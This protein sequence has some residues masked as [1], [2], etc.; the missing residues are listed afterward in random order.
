M[1]DDFN[2][3]IG[4]FVDQKLSDPSGYENLVKDAKV[5]ISGSSKTQDPSSPF[6][7]K[8]L[9]KAVRNMI[10]HCVIND[11]KIL[12]GD[13]PGVDSQVQDYLKDLD[14]KNVVVYSPFENPCYMS[15]GKWESK[16]VPGDLSKKDKAMAKDADTGIA[17]VIEGG[18]S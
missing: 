8:E 17:V 10:D 16:T 15:N 1:I 18:S 11:S 4:S 12:V 5:F 7:Q 2:A 14:Y 3:I 6:Y 9:P 13:A